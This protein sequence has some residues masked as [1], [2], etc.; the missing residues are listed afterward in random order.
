MA[1]QMNEQGGRLAAGIARV[2]RPNIIDDQPRF[3]GDTGWA[4]Y[5]RDPNFNRI[6]MHR[7]FTNGRT[8]VYDE[9]VARLFKFDLG[10]RVEPDLA[11]KESPK[12]AKGRGRKV[13]TSGEEFHQIGHPSRN[14]KRN[15]QKA[16]QGA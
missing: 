8:V 4:I 2:S 15:Q 6:V 7:Q 12:A 14:L 9:T 1:V 3:E 11:P 16:T 13:A 5:T 10:Y